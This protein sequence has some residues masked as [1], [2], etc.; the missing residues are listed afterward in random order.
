MSEQ[1][2]TNNIQR[3]AEAA[4]IQR[5]E[6]DKQHQKIV[7]LEHKVTTLS[8][9]VQQLKTMVAIMSATNAGTG[10]TAR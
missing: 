9:E 4:K 10:P 8:Q 7:S 5:A 2:N 1:N 6:Y 3:L